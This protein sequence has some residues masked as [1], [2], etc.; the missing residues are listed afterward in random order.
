MI[1]LY[2]RAG[3]QQGEQS[4]TVQHDWQG[5]C[6]VRNNPV[7]AGKPPAKAGRLWSLRR[8]PQATNRPTRGEQLGPPGMG[9]AGPLG[10]RVAKGSL[11]FVG[12]CSFHGLQDPQTR[13]KLEKQE[14][15]PQEERPDRWGSKSQA[16]IQPLAGS[17]NSPGELRSLNCPFNTSTS[18]IGVAR[19]CPTG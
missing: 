14:G 15:T 12:T 8:W 13:C 2:G 6:G 19:H 4:A 10:N 1:K 3:R 16:S 5:A 18:L 7:C 11:L 9:Q 17:F